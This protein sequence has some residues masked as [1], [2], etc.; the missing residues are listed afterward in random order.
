MIKQ[1][2]VAGRRLRFADKVT[3]NP[4]VPVG[5]WS[6]RLWRNWLSD[7]GT[8]H[9]DSPILG[10]AMA[11]GNVTDS[12][13]SPIMW[14]TNEKTPKKII[15]DMF[16][17]ISKQKQTK[18]F[19]DG[20]KIRTGNQLSR[21]TQ[22]LTNCHFTKTEVEPMSI[23]AVKIAQ[24]QLF[25]FWRKPDKA[26]LGCQSSESAVNSFESTDPKCL[27]HTKKDT[28]RNRQLHFC[29]SP[30]FPTTKKVTFALLNT[31]D[32]PFPGCLKF[33]TT[34]IAAKYRYQFLSSNLSEYEG[35]LQATPALWSWHMCWGSPSPSQPLILGC[36]NVLATIVCF[37]QLAVV[38]CNSLRGEGSEDWQFVL[39]KAQVSNLYIRVISIV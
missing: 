18:T 17:V 1:K 6:E 27:H 5:S 21:L 3:S 20:L 13:V 10:P 12:L 2:N 11:T 36:L 16:W 33:F 14:H 23:D 7:Y 37:T 19:S 29:T 25:W 30:Y 31:F 34:A 22:K 35:L 26:F 15:L 24:L 38:F 8:K 28:S 4:F 39:W 9:K 32:V